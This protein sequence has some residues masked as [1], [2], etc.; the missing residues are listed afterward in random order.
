MT[1][2]YSREVATC[3]GLGVFWKLLFRWRG[4][5]Y[6]LVWHNLVAYLFLYY[7]LSLIYRFALDE[8]GKEMF[9]HIAIHCQKFSDLIPVTFVLGFYVSIIITRWW[10]QYK[11]IPWPDSCCLFIS[12][13]IQGHDERGRLM[14]RTIARYLI[15]ALI[16]TLR[17]TSVQVKKRFP[18]LA[19]LSEAGILTEGEQK[20]IESLDEKCIQHPKYWMSLVWAGAIVTRARKEGRIKDD[21]GFQTI[22]Q[23]INKFRSGCGGLLD[24]DWISVPLVYTQVVTL[25]VY[26]FFISSL[27]GRQFLDPSKRLP[28]NEV[29]LVVPVFT[30]L[31]FFFYMGWLKVAEAL[32]NPFGEDDDD[33]EMN[34]LIDRNLQVAY[35]IVD[36]MHAEHPE[37]VK[38]QFW[39]EGVPDELPYT[40]AAEQFRMEPWLGS[41]A[42]VEI[43]PEMGEFITMDKIEEEEDS[44]DEINLIRISGSQRSHPVS[45]HKGTTK[46]SKRNSVS[47]SHR[48]SVGTLP[49]DSAGRRN[50]DR[51]VMAMLQKIFSGSNP[52]L[53]IQRIG[54]MISMNSRA[55]QQLPRVRRRRTIS[56]K[57]GGM[58]RTISRASNIS[59][60]NLSPPGMSRIQTKENEIFKMSDTSSVNS[61]H[62]ESEFPSRSNSDAKALYEVREILRNDLSKY[63]GTMKPD[64]SLQP[65][66]L[67]A[68]GEGGSSQGSG[69]I[70][71]DKKRRRDIRS[72]SDAFNHTKILKKKLERVQSVQKEIMKELDADLRMK[73]E[74]LRRHYR[75]QQQPAEDTLTSTMDTSEVISILEAKTNELKK[76]LQTRRQEHQDHSDLDT[77]GLASPSQ[78]NQY[79]STGKER[80]R[81]PTLF[82][83]VPSNPSITGPT[84]KASPYIRMEPD[85]FN[86][87]T[88]SPQPSY[89]SLHSPQLSPE[90]SFDFMLEAAAEAAAKKSEVIRDDQMEELRTPAAPGPSPYQPADIGTSQESRSQEAEQVEG[91]WESWDASNLGTIQE[92]PEL[93]YQSDGSESELSLPKYKKRSPYRGECSEDGNPLSL[94]PVPEELEH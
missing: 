80:V 85:N 88:L 14:R 60:A 53:S 79:V 5:I 33:F 46:S 34:W 61:Y 69:N 58:Q 3:T 4:S 84:P 30:F 71:T 37:L 44:D 18:T 55:G 13:V 57:S 94:T 65:L 28:G 27:M 23:E 77:D 75:Q 93:G 40:V 12:T 43:S 19:H 81:N 72:K 26:S 63:H 22:I 24:Y 31:Q 87:R 86:S 52:A 25:A 21:F 67:L 74:E 78:E 9:E 59:S 68:R 45:S 2:S 36:E 66:D 29:D 1:I 35:L 51:S 83:S 10:G 8:G 48:E 89:Q 54:S 73:K 92:L 39:E 82:I 6:K 20:I 64:T 11:I 32:I 49:A 16:Q 42:E 90:N 56:N 41:T 91:D 62:T 70:R 47:A 15:V 17:M 7:T 76:A 50:S 38:D